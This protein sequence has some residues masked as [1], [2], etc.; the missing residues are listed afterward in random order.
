MSMVIIVYS[1]THSGLI[2]QNL[3][4]SEYSYYFVLQ[5]FLPILQ[6]IG[7][8]ITVTDPSREVDAI[9]RCATQ[10][11]EDCIFLSFSPPHR[12]P[13]D[14]ACPTIPVIAWEYNTIPSETWSA[15]RHQDWR[16][17]LNK[18]GRAITLSAFSADAI[19]SAMGPDFPV[20]SIPAPIFDRFKALRE[21]SDMHPSSSR[22]HLT[23][24]NAMVDTWAVD[25]AAYAPQRVREEAASPQ[26]EEGGSSKPVSVSLDGVIYA[27]ILNPDDYR[28]NYFDL[29]GGFCRALREVEDA[30]LILKL[31]HHDA[32]IPIGN[33][34]EYLYRLSPFKCRVLLI[35]GY[36]SDEE[37]RNLL[38]ATTYAVNTSQGEGQCIPLMESMSLGKPVVAPRHTAM[39]D[40]LSTGNAF[41][42]ASTVEPA[43]WPQDPRGAYR[44]L[45]HR[46]NFESLLT[47]FTESY[48]VATK[49]LQ[50][51]ETMA[52]EA[53]K[54]L[55][56]C[57]SDVVTLERV[58]AFL[59][60]APRR[61][62]VSAD[63]GQ[64]LPAHDAYSLGD[65]VDFASEFNARRYLGR[66]WGG[67]ELGHGVWSNGALAELCFRLEQRPTGPLRLSINLTAFVVKEHP[68]VTVHVSAEDLDIARWSFSVAQPELVHGSWH[69]AIIPPEATWDK[70]LSIRLK[71]EHPASPRK[72]G[73]SGDIRSLGI[74]LHRLSIS[75]EVSVPPESVALRR[76]IQSKS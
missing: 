73:L 19:R 54:T 68:N 61:M 15:E 65:Y 34:M 41:L 10:K 37:Y 13:L 76:S 63:Y 29:L 27:A 25:L 23:I 31:S 57:N 44:A 55:E 72:L 59:A 9:Y 5:A 43:A 56:Q 3:G 47:A 26:T 38:L 69:E 46:L 40:Y 62:L 36:L 49:E 42:V 20:A 2:E 1:E 12:T 67:T 22:Q 6:Q 21:N 11:G 18:F 53:I 66:G 28:K 58:R 8:V 60:I 50:R 74:L 14:L 17:V 48:R 35:S 24:P 32:E 7:R 39:I 71:I 64:I 52:Q 45:G 51:Y 75:P 70:A 33:M 30:T 16:F 4:E